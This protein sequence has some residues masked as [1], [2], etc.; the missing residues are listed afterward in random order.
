MDLNV[1]MLA[2]GVG[3]AK[4]A[5]GLAQ[6][7]PAGKLTI[8]GNTGDDFVHCGLTICPDLDTVMH[9]LTGL[10][11]TETG[12]GRAGESWRTMEAVRVLDGPDWFNLGDVDLGTHLV[13]SHKLAQGDSLT[14]TMAALATKLGTPIPILPM[15]DQAAPT[16]IRTAAGDLPFQTWFVEHRWQPVAERIILPE[17]ISATPQ[18]VSALQAAD[19]VIIA[20]SNPYVS[21]DPILNCHPVRSLLSEQKAAV[22]AVTPIIAGDAVKGPAAKM[23][24]DWGLS[25]SAQ[26]IADFYGGLLDGF[27]FDERD[28]DCVISNS[29]QVHSTDTLMGDG[30]GR[31][32]LAQTVINFALECLI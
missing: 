25:V 9:T 6:I 18:V 10:A 13:R 32:R 8:I 31:K 3:G 11:N 15:S 28:S 22:V 23:M 5:D 4:L 29:F 26:T 19:L 14:A 24:R 30:A 17:K 2:G 1:V 16:L 27:V 12:W 7:L 20:P 21:V